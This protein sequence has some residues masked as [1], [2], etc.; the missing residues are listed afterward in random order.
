M[1]R[2]FLALLRQLRLRR[3]ITFSLQCNLYLG[4][5]LNV[6]HVTEISIQF[7]CD[8]GYFYP[9]FNLHIDRRM[10]W[11]QFHRSLKVSLGSILHNFLLNTLNSPLVYENL[12]SL[13]SWLFRRFNMV[14]KSKTSMFSMLSK[15]FIFYYR[16]IN[17]WFFNHHICLEL[18]C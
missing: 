10:H 12:A 7:C 13:F 6:Q 2:R 3:Q 9:D 17:V 15:K 16:W 14:R 1:F 4:V 18:K 5:V 8:L 11:N